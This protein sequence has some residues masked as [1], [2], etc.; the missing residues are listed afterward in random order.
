[1]KTQKT[2]ITKEIFT[3]EYTSPGSPIAFSSPGLVYQYYNKEIPYTKIQ[4]WL[5]EIDAYSLHKQAKLPKPRNPT[6]AYYKRYQFQ[7]DL[8]ELGSLSLANDDFKYLLSAID[9]FT[10]FAFVEPLKNKTAQS[11]MNGFKS[12][13]E[14]AGKFPKRILADKGGEI[15]NRIFRDYC[16]QNNILLIHSENLNHAPFIERFNRTLKS[17]MFKYMTH[18][19]TDRYID[20]LSSL[21]YSYNN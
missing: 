20:V 10:R 21:V 16:K 19:E 12:I 6:Y 18:Y 1:M 8:I 4:N 2:M 13:M 5:K 9:I 15:K 11:F 3:R 7:I 17:I 14:R